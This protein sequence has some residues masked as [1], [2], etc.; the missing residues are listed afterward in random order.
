MTETDALS[1]FKEL[2]ERIRRVLDA[3]AAA[4][5]EGSAAQRDLT[6]A[7]GQ[8][9]SLQTEM[10][11]M[12]EERLKVRNRVERLISSIEALEQTKQKVV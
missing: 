7:R 10:E 6:D 11:R 5:K 1:R 8:I 4:R 2:E 3:L 12:R 9:R